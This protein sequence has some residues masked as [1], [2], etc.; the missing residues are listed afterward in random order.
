[1]KVPIKD[2]DYVEL[3]AEKL[4]KDNSLFRQQK[5]LIESQMKSSREVFTNMCGT[6]FKLNA[7]RYLKGVGLV[8]GQ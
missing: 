8:G 6:N 5:K 7:R 1:M 2:L 3:Y 4:K